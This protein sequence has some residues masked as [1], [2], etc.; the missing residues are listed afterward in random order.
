MKLSINTSTLRR[1]FGDEEAIKMIKAAGFEC[2]DYSMYDIEERDDLLGEDYKERAQRLRKLADEIGIECNQAHAPFEFKYGDVLDESNEA[3]L[4]IVRSIE[5]AAIHGAE[6]III[7]SITRLPEGVDFCEYN[8]KFYLS[9]IPYCKRFG[10]KV[11]VE[12]LFNCDDGKYTGFLSKPQEHIDFVRS[13][14]SDCFNACVD[15][16][17]STL[18][19]CKPE[20]VIAAMD[21][22]MLC[23]L[24]IH[25]N[26]G[27]SDIHNIPTFGIHNWDKITEALRSIGYKGVFTLE[28]VLNRY[29]NEILKEVLLFTE[30]IGRYLV[31]KFN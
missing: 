11:S 30:K 22:N 13:L 16:G 9:F 21:K 15:V 1:R 28:I 2:Y 23:A 3:Y 6:N 27:R 14:N 12:N 24:H 5:A 29:E 18:T 25:D 17:H 19:G 20:D 8:R 7:H 31:R 26:Y 10:I 4:R